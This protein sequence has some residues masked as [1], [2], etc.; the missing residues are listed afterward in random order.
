MAYRNAIEVDQGRDFHLHVDRLI[1]GID[2]HLRG[3][4]APAPAA[5]GEAVPRPADSGQSPRS[6]AK[7][8]ENSL[9]MT[10]ARIEPGSFLMGST[11]E[12]I[13]QLM[14]L[15]PDSKREWFDDEQPQHRVAITRPFWLGIHQ[16]TVGQFGRFVEASGY[17]TEAEKDGQ[18]SHVWNTTKKAWELDP[19]KNWRNPGFSQEDT[20]PVVCVSHNDAVAFCQWLTTQEKYEGRTYRLPTE[21]EWEYACRAGTEALFLISDDPEDLI[22]IANVADASAKEKFPAWSCVKGNDGFVYTAPVGSFAPNS[23]GLYD[24]IGNAWE[25]CADGFD[26][27]YYASS[28]AA[29]PPGA[30]G[31][32]HRVIRGGSWY[33]NAGYCRPAY[34]NGCTPGH[35]D[36]G[37]G[38]RVAAVQE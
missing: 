14:R 21:A 29:D 31:A 5:P 8:L 15:F 37:L 12:Q 27:K 26:A 16:V 38:F 32:S 36:S 35:R 34:R 20:H 19:K 4:P 25:W 13:D 18:G 28:P 22:K 11:R 30:S 33:D 2:F 1:R 17:K 7:S 23:W 9:G 24:M 6:K 10:L 3:S